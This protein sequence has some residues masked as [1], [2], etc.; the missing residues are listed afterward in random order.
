MNVARDMEK[1]F[2]KMNVFFVTNIQK[3]ITLYFLHIMLF[4]Y[5]IPPIFIKNIRI[6]IKETKKE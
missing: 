6:I 1:L 4:S 5:Y 3:I 2:L